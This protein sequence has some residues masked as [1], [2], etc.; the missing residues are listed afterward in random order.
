MKN[1]PPL[2]SV[3]VLSY[4]RPHLL[5]HALNS[6][7]SQTYQNL[8]V[9]IS[10]NGSNDPEI[11]TVVSSF[12][13]LYPNARVFFH[14]QNR[15]AFWNFRFVLEQANSQLFVWLADDDYWSP[16]Y[17]ETLVA[18]RTPG[19]PSLGYSACAPICLETN[20][21]G[22]LVKE[23]E[24]EKRGVRNVLRQ[25]LFDSDSMTYGLFDRS[26][27]VK[28]APLLQAW[29]ISAYA[30]KR[31]PTMEVDFVSYAFLY[32]LLLEADF[33]NA[34]QIGGMH[35]MISTPRPIPDRPSLGFVAGLLDVVFIFASIMYVHILLAVRFVRAAVIAGSL[36]G[37]LFAPFAVSYLFARRVG[38]VALSRATRRRHEKQK[39]HATL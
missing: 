12:T 23:R 3:G 29:P 8:E 11:R 27:G 16:N 28:Y 31:L 21:T 33:A 4:R 24:S 10:D 26:A 32:G 7:A 30:R 15:G 17:L 39:I 25:T 36:P 13:A 38:M 22:A 14:E 2:I 6:V 18:T 35:F 20:Q 37:V 9:I 1:E 5:C 19:R 34:S